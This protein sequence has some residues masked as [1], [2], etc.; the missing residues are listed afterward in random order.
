MLEIQK[1][2]CVE[3]EV[4]QLPLWNVDRNWSFLFTIIFTPALAVTTYQGTHSFRQSKAP[5]RTLNCAQLS[6][7]KTGQLEVAHSY[8]AAESLHS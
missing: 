7:G 5:V 4:P 8:S 2:S 1:G 3:A 6:Q